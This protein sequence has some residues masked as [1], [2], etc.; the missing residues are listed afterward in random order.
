MIIYVWKILENLAPNFGIQ[1]RT[2]PRTGRFCV[3]PH[4]TSTAASR[5]QT[6]RFASLSVNG[7]RLFNA[8]PQG[9][10]NIS[11][12]SIEAFK[13][14]LDKYIVSIPDEP[15]VRALIPY[16]SK[17]SNSLLLMRPDN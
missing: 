2:N 10:R 13:S 6:I 11:E 15:R 5:V 4:V 9:I 1:S 8:M 3:V 17:S 14:A 16:C 12:C 7:P